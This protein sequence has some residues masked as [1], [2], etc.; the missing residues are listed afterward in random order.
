ME[1]PLA[2]K[3]VNSSLAKFYKDSAIK[4]VRSWTHRSFAEF[5]D[6][7]DCIYRLED[8]DLSYRKCYSSAICATALANEI[9]YDHCKKTMEIFMYRHMYINLPMICSKSSNTGSF[10]SEE[11]YGLFLQSPECYIRFMI[12]VLSEKTCS[13]ECVSLWAHAQSNSPG[14]TRHLEY[15]AQRLT[16][17]TLK[18]MRD[19]ISAAKDPEKREFMDHLPKHFRTFQQACMGPATT[20]APGLVV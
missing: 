10:C 16:G 6:V 8:F 5:C 3:F 17:I 20:L 2:R 7:N 11:S 13:A 9:P 15:H 14:C 12:P 1:A 19:L 18:F 4:M